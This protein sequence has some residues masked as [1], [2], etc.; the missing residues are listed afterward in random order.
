M[1]G[2]KEFFALKI[3]A[4]GCYETSTSLYCTFCRHMPEDNKLNSQIRENP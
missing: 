3:E 2:V 4:A 1:D